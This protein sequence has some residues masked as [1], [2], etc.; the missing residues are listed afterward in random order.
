MI[1]QHFDGGKVMIDTM[2]SYDIYH[3]YLT[4]MPTDVCNKYGLSK[5]LLTR[6]ETIRLKHLMKNLF[7]YRIF[8]EDEL[9][10]LLD[11]MQFKGILSYMEFLTNQLRGIYKI[12]REFQT[13]NADSIVKEDRSSMID[14]LMM[15]KS[16]NPI[17]VLDFDHTITN[18]KFHTL[19]RWLCEEGFSI[20]I[21]SAN[22]S[23]DTVRNYLSKNSLELP[24]KIFA[25]KGK[26]KKIVQLKV[27]ASKWIERPRFYIDDELEYLG[28]GNLLFY[29]CYQYTSNGKIKRKTLCVK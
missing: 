20:F 5:T 27:I 13:D 2:V 23:E 22:P 17:V 26:K 10:N 14:L 16:A 8:S 1:K 25:N 9:R 18:K 21:N 15:Y 6:R 12:T 24:S 19:Y 28:Y 29:Q 4:G 11:T 7:V 3:D